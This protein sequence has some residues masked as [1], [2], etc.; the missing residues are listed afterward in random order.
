MKNI[1]K[2]LCLTLII[3]GIWSCKKEENKV[4]YKSGTEPVLKVSS[5]DD[6]KLAKAIEDDVALTFSWTNPNYKFNTGVS[7]QDVNY[8][9]QFDTIG[10]NFS[11]PNL[12]ERS[13]SKELKYALAVGDLNTIMAK[14]LLLENVPHTMEV[15]LKAYLGRGSLPLYS[16]SITFT[17]T[18][19]L[20]V[21]VPLPV[22]GNLYLIGNATPGGDASGWNNPVPE[23]SQVF[24]KTSASSYEITIPLIGG[25]EYL[26]IPQNGSWD[27]KYAVKNDPPVPG[28]NEGG[29]FGY[30]W[31]QNFPGPSASGTY[32][33]ELDFKIGKFTVTKL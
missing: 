7:S 12:Q 24:T 19:Y 28:L 14:L 31:P 11:N 29:D 33:I 20:D 8:T 25:K 22:G 1:F 30:D 27:H 10:A 16:N 4:I 17:A 13:V 2:I 9:L 5:T 6:I 21:A 32:K 3:F 18:P 23:P 26:I 15:R